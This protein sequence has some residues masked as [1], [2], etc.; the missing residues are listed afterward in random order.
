MGRHRAERK[1][2]SAMSSYTSYFSRAYQF[3]VGQRYKGDPC[4]LYRAVHHAHGAHVNHELIA[5]AEALFAPFEKELLH[6]LERRYVCD[7]VVPN[8]VKYR[9]FT[10]KDLEKFKGHDNLPGLKQATGL[11]WEPTHLLQRALKHE[12]LFHEREERR[13]KHFAEKKLKDEV[14]RLEELPNTAVGC[15]AG[16][17]GAKC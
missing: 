4:Q 7:D 9:L 8:L 6:L 5:E 3:F 13:R 11:D 17:P 1:L 2:R 15:G 14:R 10:L 12:V 16:R